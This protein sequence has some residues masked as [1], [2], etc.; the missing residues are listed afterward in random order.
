MEN[1][2]KVAFEWEHFGFWTWSGWVRFWIR[3]T[4]KGD[5]L[6]ILASGFVGLLF[7][8]GCKRKSFKPCENTHVYIK[9]DSE[10]DSAVEKVFAAG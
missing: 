10:I 1:K 2:D 7:M 5:G 6:F 8:D 9:V 4:W 3:K